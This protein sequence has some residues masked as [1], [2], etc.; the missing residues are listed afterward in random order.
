MT[1]VLSIQSHVAYGHVGNS[2]AVFPLQRLGIEVWPVHTVQFSNHTGY[3]EWTGRVYDGQSIDELVQGISDR[4]VLGSCDAVLS[5][6]LGSA[7]IGHA[8]V[9]AVAR[10]RAA[11]PQAVY[12]CDPVIGDVGRGVFVRPGIAEFM[13]EVAVPAADVVTPNHYELDLLSGAT[14]RSPAS[15]KDA[16]AA[17]QALGP[18]VVLTTSLVAEDTPDDAVDLLASEGGRHWRVRTPR[19]GVSVNGAG[20]AIAAL[21][22]AHWLGTRSAADALGRAAATVFGL[23]QRTEDARSRE[24]LLVAAQEEV[25]SPSRTFEVDEV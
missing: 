17:V 14:T 13:R 20:D 3:G 23:L 9:G 22:L 1:A 15:V 25:V 21:F 19:L 6:Y 2:S 8:V 5:G 16:V 12:C 10:V 18:R 4:G 11:N 7:D 24:V